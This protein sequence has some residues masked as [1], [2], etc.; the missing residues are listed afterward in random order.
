MVRVL[1]PRRSCLAVPGSSEKM[2]V[3]AQGLAVDEVFLDLE[4]SVAPGA[5]TE[6]RS[7]VVSALK[8]GDWQGKTVVVRIND[9]ETPWAYE[10][11][12]A[13]VQGAGALIDCIMLPKVEKLAHILWLDT[14]LGQLEQSLGLPLGGIGIEVQI[15]GPAGLSI[16]DQIAGASERIETLIFGPGDF[17]ASMQLPTLTIGQTDIG[18]YNPLDPVFMSLA[19]A[20]RKH[21]IQ[22]IDGPYGVIGD[23]DGF[24]LAA[25]RAVAFGFDGKW[26]LHPS[27]VEL[28][29]TI[30]SPRQESYDRAELILQAYDYHRSDE[31]GAR[32]AVM[33]GSEM[34]DEA[35]RKMALV[36]ALQGRKAGLVRTSTFT[37]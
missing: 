4:D 34:I 11:L 20:A 13:V 33:L 16:V 31:G 6:A 3:K 25:Q 15:E 8:E 17:M 19:I 27:Q 35:S 36:T 32:G 12:L 30:F 29:N 10:D 7:R 24:A 9:A 18:G 1:R 2:L 14:S 5:K 22:V 23:L 26:V 28:A 21:G 37:P